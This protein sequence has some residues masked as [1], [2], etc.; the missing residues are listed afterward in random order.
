MIFF[1]A[2]NFNRLLFARKP[3][4][5]VY[6]NGG[7]SVVFRSYVF[8]R[9]WYEIDIDILLPFSLLDISILSSEDYVLDDSP[10]N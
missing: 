10:T 3:V 4:Y 6:D 2:V 9:F 1:I 8:F 7:L 5:F